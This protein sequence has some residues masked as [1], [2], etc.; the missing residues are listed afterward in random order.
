MLK[1]A[2]RAATVAVCLGVGLATVLAQPQT[3]GPEPKGG[4]HAL[5]AKNMLGA[6]VDLQGGGSVGTI[7]DIVFD[8]EGVID[9]FVVSQNGKLVTV[10]WEAAKFNFEKR[11]AT[12]NITEEQYRK[13]PTYTVETYPQFYTPTYQTEIYGY[14]NLKP[15]QARRF[16][17]RIRK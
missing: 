4:A 9:Y 16:E 12:I 10:P 14:Y 17:R 15:G 8:D 3:K 1:T 2:L 6:K 11:T 13:I 7:E 5:H